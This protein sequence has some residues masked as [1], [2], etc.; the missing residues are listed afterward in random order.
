L[1]ARERVHLTP[2]A[3]LYFSHRIDCFLWR[4]GFPARPI[5]RSVPSQLIG[6]LKQIWN[7][8]VELS[9]SA[10]HTFAGLAGVAGE[11]VTQ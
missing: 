10:E 2:P 9:V 8:E 7:C 11:G 3:K 4:S 5:F 6:K 1:F